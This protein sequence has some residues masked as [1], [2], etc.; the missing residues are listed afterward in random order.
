MAA[1]NNPDPQH[2]P[3]HTATS[4]QLPIFAFEQAYPQTDRTPADYQNYSIH[5]APL[6]QHPVLEQNLP[7]I[8]TTSPDMR[9]K[10]RSNDVE[11]QAGLLKGTDIP[12]WKPNFTETMIMVTLA[13]LSLMVS[14]DATV[15]VTSL[16]VCV[17]LSC[18]R[19]NL[20]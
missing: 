10:E 20:V 5:S 7:V 18:A 11:Q 13:I 17:P 1:T 15:I 6:G 14:L 12:K 4:G 19:N 16:S 8:D 9:S 3:R 2:Y